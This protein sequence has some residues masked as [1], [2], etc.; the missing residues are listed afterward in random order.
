MKSVHAAR[1]QVLIQLKEYTA[2]RRRP[3]S[4]LLP[5][6]LVSAT[7]IGNAMPP[8]TFWR[9]LPQLGSMVQAVTYMKCQLD[10]FNDVYHGSLYAESYRVLPLLWMR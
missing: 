2:V 4:A 5:Q 7:V 9:R 6:P 10:R 8:T 3:D 1:S